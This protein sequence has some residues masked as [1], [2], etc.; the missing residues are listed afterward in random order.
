MFGD[1]RRIVIL[2][3]HPLGFE[4][5]KRVDDSNDIQEHLDAAVAYLTGGPQ[6]E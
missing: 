4:I 5:F 1:G 2:R 3:R 6:G